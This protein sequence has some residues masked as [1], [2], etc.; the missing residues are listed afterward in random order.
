MI[1][2]VFSSLQLFHPH[3]PLTMVFTGSFLSVALVAASLV[4]A[5]SHVEPGSVEHLRR[6]IFQ[7]NARRSLANC[8]ETLAKR[9]GVYERAQARR[10][11]YAIKARKEKSLRKSSL[12]SCKQYLNHFVFTRFQRSFQA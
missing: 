4:S 12:S 3:P 10:E 7:L 2:L 9:D 8:Q 1:F 5:H 6:E 11:A